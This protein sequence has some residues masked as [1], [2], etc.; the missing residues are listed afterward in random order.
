ME[1]TD[2]FYII[3]GTRSEFESI[4]RDKCGDSWMTAFGQTGRIQLSFS[5]FVYVNHPDK[6]VGIRNPRGFFYG[7][8]KTRTDLDQVFGRLFA[9]TEI[10][11]P[12]YQA[13]AGAR[14]QLELYKQWMNC[15]NE[16]L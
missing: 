14:K 15:Q 2:K 7:T 5:D 3:C 10:D 4:I 9:A 16:I 8:W 12:S 1:N 6:L 13:I 11:S